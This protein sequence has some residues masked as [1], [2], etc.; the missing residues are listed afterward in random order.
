M[1]VSY[2]G[3][4]GAVAPAA[5]TLLWAE[6][7]IGAYARSNR[8]PYPHRS[9][10]PL[11]TRHSPLTTR[12]HPHPHPHTNPRPNLGAYE[13]GIGGEHGTDVR[14]RVDRCLIGKRNIATGATA[15]ERSG[16]G[17]DG[18]GLANTFDWG[19][20]TRCEGEPRPRAASLAAELGQVKPVLQALHSS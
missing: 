2:D 7:G 1:M 5:G 10:S 6:E 4:S 16:E 9:P 8:S 14:V 12:P 20:V 19:V 17:K 3:Q 15:F 11:T 13:R 18:A